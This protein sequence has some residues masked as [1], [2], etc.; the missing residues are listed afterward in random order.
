M[1]Q[2]RAPS[3]RPGASARVVASLAIGVLAVGNVVFALLWLVAPLG[4]QAD[5]EG[6]ERR[7]TARAGRRTLA[8]VEGAE[9]G[10]FEAQMRLK[11]ATFDALANS[12]WRLTQAREGAELARAFF[13]SDAG[14]AAEPAVTI[15]FPRRGGVERIEAFAIDAQRRVCYCRVGPAREPIVMGVDI[16]LKLVSELAKLGHGAVGGFALPYYMSLGEG[17]KAKLAG[18]KQTLHVTTVSANTDQLLLDLSEQPQLVAGLQLDHPDAATLTA[19]LSLPPHNAMARALALAMGRAAERVTARHLAAREQAQDVTDLAE[20]ARRPVGEVV[21]SIVLQYGGRA[22]IIRS[23]DLMATPEGGPTASAPERFD[24]EAVVL[25]ALEELLTDRGVLYLAQGH[26]ERR[27]D[28]VSL[29]G[30]SRP[31][32]E[33]RAKGFRL[34]ALDLKQ[35]KTVPDDAKALVLAGPLEAYSPEVEAR[36]TRYVQGGGRLVVLCHPPDAPPVLPVLLNRY[37]IAEAGPEDQLAICRVQLDRSIDAV[38]GWTPETV[39]LLT[40]T[41]LQLD[42]SVESKGMRLLCL[43]RSR[44]EPNGKMVCVMA[45]TVPAAGK[46]GPRVLV[47]GDVDAFTNLA[48]NVPGA[49]LRSPKR[50]VQVRANIDLLVQAILWLTE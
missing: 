9:S 27:L 10:A 19:T 28:D 13:D 16:Y 21:D 29:K 11:T 32:E 25:R 48:Y 44:K 24:G 4:R 26:G 45:A 1:A 49:L 2:E 3:P 7:M 43:A 18:L 34:V 30:L 6:G 17:L 46:K 15:E 12:L 38:R 39:V 41:A 14:K 37:G 36:I 20:A 35:A 47:L 23:R 40:A 50:Y 33:L 8:V 31:A 42:R 22:R 5:G